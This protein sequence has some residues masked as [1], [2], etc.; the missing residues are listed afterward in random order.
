MKKIVVIGLGDVSKYVIKG[1]E[2][3]NSFE[4]V[5]ICDNNPK[6]IEE[7][8][9]LG[10]DK[11]LDYKEMIK[12]K[13]FDYV[14]L[15]VHHFNRLHI[16]NELISKKIKVICEKPIACSLKELELLLYYCNL[17][18]NFPI[19]MY[20]RSYNSMIEKFFKMFDENN[21]KMIDI[22]YLED[23]SI[24]SSTDDYKHL[25]DACGGGCVQ[26]NFPNC[27]HYL[28]SHGNL[29]LIDYK[30]TKS[31]NNI[32]SESAKVKML[33]N[34]IP[35]NINLDWNSEIDDKSI[36][37]YCD[38]KIVELNLQSNYKKP[39]ESLIDEYCN[40]FK[41]FENFDFTKCSLIDKQ[42]VE[43]INTIIN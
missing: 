28:L 43:L 21:V 1:I 36:I 35:C 32:Y 27:V 39:K 23:I 17:Y 7:F 11:F 38:K 5:A 13:E 30:T 9:D 19:I 34:G 31:L 16:L 40:F 33:F 18:N 20:H 41:T 24:H 14:V 6:R 26:D 12:E 25:S 37:V 8:L 42:I 3:S 2:K 10:V 15:L 4:I 22:N 29:S